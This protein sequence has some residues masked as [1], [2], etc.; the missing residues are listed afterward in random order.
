M[1]FS[2]SSEVCLMY[3]TMLLILPEQGRPQCYRPWPRVPGLIIPPC[4]MKA[5]KAHIQEPF[6]SCFEQRET[7]FA[8]CGIHAF[9]FTT[10][11]KTQ[12]CVD[13][14]AKWLKRRFQRLQKKGIC[15]Y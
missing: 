15:C 11:N 1:P 9:L 13:P 3:L 6:V 8:H 5:S 12:Y 4:C 14:E 2:I 10:A 7:T